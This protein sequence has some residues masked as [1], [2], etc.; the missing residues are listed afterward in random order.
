MLCLVWRRRREIDLIKITL[1]SA[2]LTSQEIKKLAEQHFGRETPIDCG[3]QNQ[4]AVDLLR[5]ELPPQDPSVDN[6]GACM[7]R[8]SKPCRFS[9]DVSGAK[10]LC[11]AKS[12]SLGPWASC[13]R[14]DDII[15][16]IMQDGGDAPYLTASFDSASGLGGE[17]EMQE[18]RPIR[19]ESMD[20]GL[21]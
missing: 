9:D 2:G 7:F 19:S 14:V 1:N 8:S 13:I 11:Q 16:S 6:C 17:I 12:T 4:V 3:V 20:R 15:R 10:R 21:D 5:E 18:M